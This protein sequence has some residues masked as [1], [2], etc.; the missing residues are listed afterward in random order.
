M[1]NASPQSKTLFSRIFGATQSDT[2]AGVTDAT[3]KD[4]EHYWDFWEWFCRRLKVDKY[5]SGV[6]R[7]QQLDLLRGYARCVREG[8]VG[9]GHKIRVGSVEVALRAVGKKFTMAC[10]PDP[11]KESP[12]STSRPVLLQ[13]MLNA[14]KKSDPPT[15]PKLA[16]PV[17]LVESMVSRSLARKKPNPKQD[18][19][20]DLCNIAFYYLLRVGEYTLASLDKRRQTTPFRV[21]DITLRKDGY[22]IPNTAP[23]HELLQAD[24]A[25]LRI[26][27]QKNGVR[28]QCIHQQCTG[29]E[30]SPIKSLARRIRN[31][32][33]ISTIMYKANIFN[34]CSYFDRI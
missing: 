22:T 9:R 10:Q 28:G 25:T 5:L 21:K 3:A 23:L 20:A 13:S 16:V 18:A 1:E 14:Y 29:T 30:L 6:P 12:N 31:I 8:F 32:M 2:A 26:T 27:N 17:T 33:S 15:A 24:E 19:I 11:T 34:F 4:H 7:M